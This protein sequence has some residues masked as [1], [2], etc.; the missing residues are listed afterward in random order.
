MFP[1]IY[2]LFLLPVLQGCLVVQTPKCE[3]PILALSSSNIAQNVGNHVFYQNVSGYPTASPVVK[4][5]DCSVSMY[6]EGDYSLV[7]FDEETATVL[8]AYS[9]DGICDPRN[10]KW[11]V[12]TGSGAGFTSFDRLFGICVNYVP[13]CACTYHVINND[14]EAKELLSSHVEWPMLST[15]KYSTPTLNSETECPTSFECQEGHEKI[16]VNEWFSIWEGITTFECMSDTKAW[17]VGLYPFPN[18]AYL[19]IGCYKT[20]TCESSIP[21]SYKAVENPEIDL[22]NHHFYQTNISKY[23]HSPPQTIL[24]ETDKCRLEFADCVSPYALIL[25]DDYD[26]VLVHLKSWGNVVGK[27]LAG[28]KWLVYNQY[29]FKQF[30]G[31]CVDFTRLRASDP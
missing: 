12:D 19:V 2:L 8:G 22:A 16:I 7:V 11:Q 17:T 20:E 9:A 6:C 15:Y 1:Y 23:Y 4:S 3:C 21:C 13:T 24:S 28:S 18:K 25:L 30:N 27:C 31:I 26:R 14:A 5:E 29:T 10:Q